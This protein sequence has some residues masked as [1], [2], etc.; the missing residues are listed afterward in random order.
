MVSGNRES[1][2]NSQSYQEAE[3]Q[4]REMEGIIQRGREERKQREGREVRE[5]AAGLSNERRSNA[6]AQGRY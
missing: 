3:D 1:F 5:R 4:V 6:E 2:Y